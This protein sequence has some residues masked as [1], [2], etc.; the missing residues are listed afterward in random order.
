MFD[1]TGKVAIVT[2]GSGAFGGAAAKALAAFGADIAMSSRNPE[3]LE[4]AADELRALSEHEVLSIPCDATDEASVAAM[5]AET[6]EKLGHV[7]ILVTGSG[8]T[9]RYPAE[10]YPI[11]EWQ[12]V[13]DSLVRA[14]FIS[15]QAA[16]REMIKQGGGGKIITVGSLRGELGHPGG[17]AGYVTAKG[18]VHLLTK[19]LATEWAKYKINV[20]SIAPCVFWTPLTQPILDDPKLYEVFMQRIPLKRAAELNDLIGAVVYLASAASDMVTGDILMVDGGATAG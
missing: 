16:G 13:I 2:G 5:V 15:C 19:Q 18:A 17:Y 1:V 9:N 7:D 8:V 20:N 4:R 10:E 3:N 6:V 11:D 14:T 12:K